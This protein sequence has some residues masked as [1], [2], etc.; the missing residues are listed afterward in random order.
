MPSNNDQNIHTQ[1]A[2]LQANFGGMEKLGDSKYTSFQAL[3]EIKTEVAV[4]KQK[5]ESLETRFND[6]ISARRYMTATVISTVSLIIAIIMAITNINFHITKDETPIQ[7][8]QIKNNKSKVTTPHLTSN[9]P[10]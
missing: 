10:Q 9:S 8:E 7:I 5:I 1:L 2:L 4:C 3:A 6:N